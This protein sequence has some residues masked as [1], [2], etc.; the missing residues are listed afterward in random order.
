M[1]I[2]PKLNLN[3]NPRLSDN[4]SLNDSYNMMLSK[5][6]NLTTENSIQTNDVIN[7]SIVNYIGNHTYSIIYCISCNIELV[8]FVLDKNINNN[9]IMIFRYNEE[10]DK[11]YPIIDNF[12]YFDGKL[13]GDF[14]Y[15]K[16]NLIISIG[17]YN[18]NG[19][20]NIPLRVI[21]LGKFPANQEESDNQT[22]INPDDKLALYDNRLHPIC[23]EVIIP[24]VTTECIN[25]NSYKGW[26]YIFIRYKISNNTYTKWL[27]TNESIFVDE[28]HQ[29]NIVDYHISKY[30]NIDDE[31]REKYEAEEDTE[32]TIEITEYVS[33]N[34]DIS[35]NSF[36]M[37]FDNLDSK[38]NVFQVALICLSKSYTKGF[39]S[40][41]INIY[42]DE[43]DNSV[44]N[45]INF[46]GFNEY[47]VGDII[48][49]YYNY[50]NVKTL[51]S[52]NNRLYIG[53]Y[54]E[55]ENGG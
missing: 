8:L 9:K 34:T 28:Y 25:G 15:N 26:Y 48:K 5:D 12:E 42:K 46:S 47:A 38:Y 45:V 52:Y 21:N 51:H 6:G 19:I 54:N 35:S 17:E 1:N 37:I 13:V 22:F 36:K 11:C 41:D 55:Y 29:E 16:D 50:Y 20:N 32:S 49:L 31:F 18:E 40:E 23:P 33:N 14:T 4:L 27:N 30:W 53:N 39:K 43:N 2:I 10:Y 44:A 3:D 24:K 7:N